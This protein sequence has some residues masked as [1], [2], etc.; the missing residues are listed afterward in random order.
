MITRLHDRARLPTTSDYRLNLRATLWQTLRPSTERVSDTLRTVTIAVRERH[1]PRDCLVLRVSRLRVLPVYVYYSFFVYTCLQS[2]S[3][4]ALQTPLRITSPHE[5]YECPPIEYNVLRATT[6]YYTLETLQSNCP[7]RRKV[8]ISLWRKRC[9]VV[10]LLVACRT[11]LYKMC[12]LQCEVSLHNY[13]MK[14]TTISH[15]IKTALDIRLTTVL[16]YVKFYVT[17]STQ[18]WISSKSGWIYLVRKKRR[19]VHL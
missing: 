7:S 19:S 4:Y 1:Y 17:D 6:L 3:P 18:I 16:C 11:G 5:S 8:S 10:L 2:T 13:N 14:W 12:I 15:A 9:D